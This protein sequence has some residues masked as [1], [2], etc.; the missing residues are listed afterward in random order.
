M[1]RWLYFLENPAGI[2]AP[3]TVGQLSDCWTDVGL[4]SKPTAKNRTYQ[5]PAQD[6]KTLIKALKKKL[7]D[8]QK[9]K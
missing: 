7:A 1:L 8:M 3:M 4:L 2:D 6:K 5:L 9:E